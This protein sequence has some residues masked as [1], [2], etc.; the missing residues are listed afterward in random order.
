M[1][2]RAKILSAGKTAAGIV[3]P[4]EFVA[5]LASNRHPRVRVTVGNYTFRT[6]IAS[7]GGRF[8]LPI[9]AEVRERAGVTAGELVELDID[10]DQAPRE[11]DL[12]A[13]FASALAADDSA[14]RNFK[15]L[16]YSNKRRLVLAIEAAKS[17][18]TRLRRI[19][20]TVTALREGRA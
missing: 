5:A 20:K 7:M 11:V 9:S 1:R 19:E 3:V 15:A 16:S 13:D 10:L 18:D 6:S 12:P 4:D 14:W 17:A 2:L 8:M